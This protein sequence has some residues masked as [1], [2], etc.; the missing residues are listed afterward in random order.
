MRKALVLLTIFILFH[1]NLPADSASFRTTVT[2][3]DM[4]VGGDFW[5]DL[6]VRITGGTSPRTLNSLT[7]D[8]YFGS[9]IN[10][11]NA[12]TWAYGFMQGYS[13]SAID[14]TSYIRA[15]TTGNNVNSEGG[16]SP[17]GWNVTGSWQTIV[18][19][20]FTI[21]VA[22]SVSIFISDNTDAAAYFN[23]LSNNPLGG[24]TDWTMDNED[25][26][27][28]PLPVILSS[29]SAQYID[30]TV[31]IYWT[32]AS[33]NNNLGWNIYRSISANFGQVVN[34]N[35]ELIS[36]AG[37]SSISTDYV[38][39]DDYDL[40][41][42]TTY[43]YWLECIGLAGDSEIYG[44][45]T[46]TIPS[47]QE[48]NIPDIPFKYG[49]YQNYPNPFNPDT[50]ISFALEQPGQC[51]LNIYNTRGQLIRVLFNEY[52]EEDRIYTIHWDGKTNNG[53]E[54]NSGL[55]FYEIRCGNNLIRK[56]ML[57][58]K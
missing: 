21:A 48:E 2:K 9:E 51:V 15:G 29:F 52:I 33:E 57:M 4:I 44:S 49:L 28:V 37:N 14:L 5:L 18:T 30:N 55:Y 23:N 41:E 3:N 7:A 56:K 35:S 22:T 16:G 31:T 38:Y 43:W 54:V 8:V 25:N 34:I 47:D 50:N 27:D 45:V 53:Y 24:V 17:P 10:Y 32:T 19:L 12:D 1:I 13:T 40:N 42:N 39:T 36:G 26:G 6:Q 20:K 58:M 46:L 11:V